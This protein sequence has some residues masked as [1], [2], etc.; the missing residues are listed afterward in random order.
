MLKLNSNITF[1][2]VVEILIK[3]IDRGSLTN[4][5]KLV[6]GKRNAIIKKTIELLVFNSYY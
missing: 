1:Q 2:Y 3:C 5:L 6:R 4:K